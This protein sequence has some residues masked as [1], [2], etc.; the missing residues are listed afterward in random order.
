MRTTFD[1]S[2]ELNVPPI[3]SA[4]LNSA[5]RTALS[6]SPRTISAEK[7]SSSP[8]SRA[9]GSSRI[10]VVVSQLP[11]AV[12]PSV[13]QRLR[14]RKDAELGRRELPREDWQH[15]DAGDCRDDLRRQVRGEVAQRATRLCQPQRPREPHAAA[16]PGAGR[17]VSR[18]GWTT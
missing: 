18:H 9:A 1:E 13:I 16:R 10:S 15:E 14:D 12:Q 5:N 7:R 11:A 8:A 4:A 6:P 2:V 3:P 17:C